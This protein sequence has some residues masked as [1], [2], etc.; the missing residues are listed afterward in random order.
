MPALKAT[1]KAVEDKIKIQ[2]AHHTTLHLHMGGCWALFEID[3]M[4]VIQGQREHELTSMFE[5]HV[6]SLERVKVTNLT[7]SR[8][9][10]GRP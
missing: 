10:F 1:L 3:R 4:R 2:Q 6:E 7:T 9:T 8:H 5:D